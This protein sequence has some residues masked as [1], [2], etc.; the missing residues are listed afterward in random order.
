[1]KEFAKSFYKSK[2]WQRT[3]EAYAKSVG[4]LCE[5]CLKRGVYK[6]GD[7]VHHRQALTP[8]NIHDPSVALAWS[9]LKLVCR[10]CHAKEHGGAKRYRVDE[11][12]RVTPRG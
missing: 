11:M 6:P 7:I 1:M 4:W 10:D 2:A 5:D 3:R 8:E 12:G 9:N